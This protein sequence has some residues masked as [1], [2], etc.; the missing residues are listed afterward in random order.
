MGPLFQADL[1][2]PASTLWTRGLFALRRRT[3]SRPD[4]TGE[5]DATVM[6]GTYARLGQPDSA[7]SWLERSLVKG[8][9]QYTAKSFELNPKLRLLR[10]APAFERMLRAHSR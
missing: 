3:A 5:L 6:A 9:G 4:G 8:V 2:L 7:V 10:G 1:T